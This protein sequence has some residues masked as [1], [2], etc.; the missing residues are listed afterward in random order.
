MKKD[1]IPAWK[2]IVIVICLILPSLIFLVGWYYNTY[3]ID[4]SLHVDNARFTG[5][6]AVSDVSEKDKA[7]LDLITSVVTTSEHVNAAS[8][9]LNGSI[10][11]VLR[12]SAKSSYMYYR[13]YWISKNDSY[14]C[15]YSDETGRLFRVSDTN[16]SALLNSGYLAELY[17]GSVPPVL[18]TADGSVILPSN[19]TWAYR[20][21]AGS[22]EFVTLSFK[23]KNSQIFE[24]AGMISFNFSIEP[25]ATSVNIYDEEEELI[26]YGTVAGLNE[27]TLLETERLRVELSAQWGST[28]DAS[29][30]Q[31]EYSFYLN[32]LA[33][34]Q[35]EISSLSVEA[36]GLLAVRGTNIMTPSRVSF[37]SSPDIT[38][39]PVFYEDTSG[40]IC[41]VPFSRKLEPGNYSLTFTYGGSSATYDVQV[42]ESSSADRIMNYTQAQTEALSGDSILSELNTLLGQTTLVQS[43]GRTFL[44]SMADPAESSAFSLVYEFGDRLTSGDFS[45]TSLGS[46]YSSS[47]GTPVKAVGGGAVQAIGYN[48]YLGNYIVIDHGCGL[49]TW[50]A[51]MNSAGVTIGQTVLEGQIIGSAGASG[52]TDRYGFL[53]LASV[54]TQWVNPAALQHLPEQ[55]LSSVK[56]K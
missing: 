8:E 23:E 4:D 36:G 11:M 35:F 43:S 54:G 12:I 24:Q 10:Q 22:Y 21:Q 17:P 45:F 32:Y 49:R 26:Y 40:T 39:T 6:K 47:S 19:G 3:L 38:T 5:S 1:R 9:D 20:N 53:L 29:V 13:L 14:I 51:H 18:L 15:Y 7:M 41:L 44:A 50:Y 46:F 42:T 31:I 56:R 27:E 16:V 52:I 28:G 37:T 33:P 25:V 55:F 30:G 48:S 2:V 34:A